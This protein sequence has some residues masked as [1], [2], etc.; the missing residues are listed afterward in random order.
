MAGKIKVK[1][2]RILKNYARIIEEHSTHKQRPTA[3]PYMDAK[4]T[5][6]N[7]VLIKEFGNFSKNNLRIA[8]IE[9]TMH[10]EK[11]RESTE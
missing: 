11:A 4:T 8:A 9:I 7:C 3:I 5:W 10:T 1:Y 6:R 2:Q